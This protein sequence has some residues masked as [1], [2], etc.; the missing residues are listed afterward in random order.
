MKKFLHE[1][2]SNVQYL[3]KCSA[4]DSMPIEVASIE[5]AKHMFFGCTVACLYSDA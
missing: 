3:L 1:S 5:V 2:Y 4:F